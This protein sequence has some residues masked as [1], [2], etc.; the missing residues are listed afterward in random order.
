VRNRKP[1]QEYRS[2]SPFYRQNQF[3]RSEIE[4]NIRDKRAVVP[5]QREDNNRSS[6]FGRIGNIL[7]N[8]STYRPFKIEG[9]SDKNSVRS[10]RS[11]FRNHFDRGSSRPSIDRSGSSNRSSVN[12]SRSSSSTRSRGTSNNNRS[13]SSRSRGNN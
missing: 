1:V 8:G 13:S 12:R 5:V 6:I 10:S 11:I 2:Y 3:N 9:R 4:S 7:K